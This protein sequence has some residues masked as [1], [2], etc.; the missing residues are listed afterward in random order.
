MVL[1]MQV[2][3]ASS[4]VPV[5]LVGVPTPPPSRSTLQMA[6][7]LQRG[8]QPP[9]PVGSNRP[10]WSHH[11]AGN[12]TTA[13]P[14]TAA[15]VT[16]PNN[17]NPQPLPLPLP[18]ASTEMPTAGLS[19]G[20]VLARTPMATTATHVA[21]R[22]TSRNTATSPPFGP[23]SSKCVNDDF[24]LVTAAARAGVQV[25]LTCDGSPV[26]WCDHSDYIGRKVTF[27]KHCRK[28]CDLCTGR[29]LPNDAT[30]TSPNSVK[31]QYSTQSRRGGRTITASSTTPTTIVYVSFG[32]ACPIV[33]VGVVLISK[34]PYT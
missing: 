2:Q 24:A 19:N 28:R 12:T 26:G 30:A 32:S 15:V 18:H 1:H 20:S 8:R 22:S 16:L 5:L 17:P 29:L 10:G 21:A 31:P 6:P 27:W 34:P 25:A 9:L 33:D 7:L 14:I 11:D 23:S 13:D 4:G 3:A